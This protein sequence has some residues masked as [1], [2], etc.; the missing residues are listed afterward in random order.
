[1]EVTIKLFATLREGRFKAVTWDLSEG[2]VV[3]EVLERLNIK[4][5]EVS[6]LLVNG[7]EAK[8][9]QVLSEGDVMSAFPPIGGG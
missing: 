6:V 9:C 2:T 5:E 4:Q 3:G 8:V 7:R 1:M